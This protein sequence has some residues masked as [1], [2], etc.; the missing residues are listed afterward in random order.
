MKNTIIYCQDSTRGKLSF[1]LITPENKEY[2]LFT[3]NF[4]AITYNMFKNGVTLDKALDFSASRNHPV[5]QKTIEKFPTYIKYLEKEYHFVVL[6][7][8]IKKDR[9][10]KRRWNDDDI[11]VA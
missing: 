6:K 5:L 9:Q 11:E 3:Q 7:Q 8:S 10:S 4:R 2:Y 1:Y